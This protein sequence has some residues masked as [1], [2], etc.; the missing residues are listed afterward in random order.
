MSSFIFGLTNPYPSFKI[1][2]NH[3]GVKVTLIVISIILFLLYGIFYVTVYANYLKTV[4]QCEKD[5]TLPECTYILSSQGNNPYTKSLLQTPTPVANLSQ[6]Q[7]VAM[8]ATAIQPFSQK[9]IDAGNEL[10][11]ASNDISNSNWTAASDDCQRALTDYQDAKK[12]LDSITPPTVLIPDQQKL[13]QAANDYIEGTTLVSDGI[14]NTDENTVEDGATKIS[15]AN[16]IVQ[17]VT[18]DMQQYENQ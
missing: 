14:K 1:S 5:P 3:K 8:Y 13:D 2:W 9:L 15:N 6:S 10:T 12:T 16:S 4:S 18:T 7:Q 17:A 11:N